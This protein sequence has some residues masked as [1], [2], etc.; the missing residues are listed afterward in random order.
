VG[1]LDFLKP[2]FA[3]LGGTT[4]F[5][6]VAIKPGKPF[7]HGR[8]DGRHWFG[9]PGNPVSAWVT[10]L[11]LV[12]P[13]LLAM[14][15]AARTTLPVAWGTLRESLTNPGDRRHFIR[16]VIADTGE[17][18]SAGRQGS[19]AQANGLVDVA[20]KSALTAGARVKVLCFPCG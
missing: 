12:R 14:Q 19:L 16:V 1:E 8:W 5:W 6:K 15:G 13:V 18:R 4:A 3:A 2:A 10:F 11:L 7:V 20:P 9:L 17:V